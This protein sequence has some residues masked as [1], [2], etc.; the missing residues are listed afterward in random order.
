[1]NFIFYF[2]HMSTDTVLVATDTVKFFVAKIK[3]SASEA[4]LREHFESFGYTVEK[5]NII[6]ERNKFG[7]QDRPPR[8]KGFGFVE[9]VIN[10]NFESNDK[11]IE[12]TNGSDFQGMN[13]VVALAREKQY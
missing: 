10:E 3:F 4:E 2:V 8:S 1:M 11:F 5:V 7:D 12:D 9:I 6:K 13:L